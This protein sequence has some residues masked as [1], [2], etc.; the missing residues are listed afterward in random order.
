[1]HLDDLS[2]RLAT[3][4]STLFSLKRL[5]ER[6]MRRVEE[7]RDAI[8]ALCGVW[9]GRWREERSLREEQ[10]LLLQGTDWSHVG[11]GGL[12]LIFTRCRWPS[13]Q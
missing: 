8:R 6:E 13:P 1:M 7:E 4:E 5:H 3:S 10:A 11:K 12:T 2:N 9:E